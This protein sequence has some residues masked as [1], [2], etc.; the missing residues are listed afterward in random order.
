[1][2]RIDWA[3]LVSALLANAAA[4]EI[5]AAQVHHTL[6]ATIASIA[7]AERQSTG[8]DTVGLTGGVFQNTLL[9]KLTTAMLTR[10]GFRV[11]LAARV[12]CGDGGLSF[13]QIVETLAA[14]RRESPPIRSDAVPS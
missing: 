1:L 14:C 3:P 12:P 8:V 6:A 7:I 5:A 11:L 10:Q 13:G 9:T 4:V 2:L